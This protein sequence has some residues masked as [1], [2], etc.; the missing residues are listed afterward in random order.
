[1]PT[2]TVTIDLADAEYRAAISLPPDELRR[3]VTETVHRFATAPNAPPLPRGVITPT[4]ADPVSIARLRAEA[5]ADHEAD[6]ALFA[7][8]EA[9]AAELTEEERQAE[10]RAFEEHMSNINANRAAIGERLIYPVT[11]AK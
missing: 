5:L 1:M 3:A 11:L 6:V 4:V 7:Q 8:W 9:E 2:L 10:S